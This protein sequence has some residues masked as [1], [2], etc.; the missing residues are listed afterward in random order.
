MIDQAGLGVNSVKSSYTTPWMEEVVG[1]PLRF[2]KK[3]IE[4]SV[5]SIEIVSEFEETLFLSL[6]LR[7]GDC[8]LA[9]ILSHNS[10]HAVCTG[11]TQVFSS[12]CGR[13]FYLSWHKL[14]SC[15]HMPGGQYGRQVH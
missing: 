2:I 10:V 14:V 8:L 3:N 12:M 7:A 1:H 13:R 4:K 15:S 9:G 11:I 5:S 6:K